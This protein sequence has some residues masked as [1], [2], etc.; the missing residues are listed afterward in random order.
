MKGKHIIIFSLVIAVILALIYIRGLAT[1]L[2]IPVIIVAMITVIMVV[3]ALFA[4]CTVN[5]NKLISIR[6][7][8]KYL[9]QSF[10]NFK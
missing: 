7:Y 1:L 10:K 6:G 3:I 2:L 4:Y 9:K 5:Y 8:I